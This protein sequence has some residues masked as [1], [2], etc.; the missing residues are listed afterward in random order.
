MNRRTG[1]VATKDWLARH[2]SLSE[3]GKP[4][5][6]SKDSKCKMWML[7]LRISMNGANLKELLLKPGEGKTFRQ[8]RCIHLES[9]TWKTHLATIA[10]GYHHLFGEDG[11]Q[12]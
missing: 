1:C 8:V 2:V 3:S 9:G 7:T 5:L 11:E 12:D 4:V 10:T 6:K